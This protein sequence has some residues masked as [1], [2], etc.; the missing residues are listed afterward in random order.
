MVSMVANHLWQSTLFAVFVGLLTLLFRNNGAH[1]RHGLWLAASIKFLLPFSVL[2][3]LGSQLPWHAN[4]SSVGP[5]SAAAQW[6]ATL[7]TIA[8]PMP[9]SEARATAPPQSTGSA[10]RTS[11]RA[12]SSIDPVS[13]L[14]ALWVCGVAIVLFVSLVRWLRIS[15]IRRGAQPF[16][17]NLPT[18]VCIAVKTSSAMMEPG[19]IGVLRPTLLMPDGIDELLSPEQLQ[20]IVAHELCH[21]RRRDNLTGVIHMIVEA[22]CWFHPLVWW[23]GNRLIEERERACDE[24]VLGG[25]SDPYIYAEGLLTVCEAYVATPLPCAAGVSGADLNKRIAAIMCGK[26]AD[27]LHV[28]KQVLLMGSV[29]VSIAAPIVVGVLHAPAALALAHGSPMFASVSIRLAWPETAQKSMNL[30]DGQFRLRGNALRSIIA[31]AYGKQAT[32]VVGP[33]DPLSQ[34]YS[35]DGQ[36]PFVSLPGQIDADARAMLR[37]LLADRFKLAFH[38]EERRIPVYVLRN[39]TNFGITQA[40]GAYE[41]GPIWLKGFNSVGGRALPL[42][43][44]IQYLSTRL[45]RPIV[46][47]TGLSGTY[48]FKLQW[49]LEPNDPSARAK[50]NDVPSDPDGVVLVDGIRRQLGMQIESQQRVVKLLTVDRVVRP[51][52]TPDLPRALALDP[53]LSGRYVGH[54]SLAGSTILAVTRDGDHLLARLPGQIPV[55]YFAGNESVFFAKSIDAQITWMTDTR[56]QVTELVLHQNGK[57]YLAPRMDETVAQAQMDALAIRVRAQSAAP[58]TEA[59]LR[60]YIQGLQRGDLTLDDWIPSARPGIRSQGATLKWRFGIVGQLK[61]LTFKGVTQNGFD[62]YE[63]CFEKDSFQWTIRL[64]PDGKIDTLVFQLITSSLPQS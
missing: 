59:E 12:K 48:N 19:V 57:D 15:A 22:V 28:A 13:I 64:A 2:I 5:G 52:Q 4:S 44:L 26:V 42:W 32:E 24:A 60:R 17:G 3:A 61:S 38:W 29:L 45:D 54:Y 14:F 43:R 16:S 34:Y 23:I 36:A 8:Q 47:E 21:V 58:G 31:Y 27:K 25:G 51:A 9:R 46:D 40:A 37:V 56:G 63:S 7:A 20:A 55:A 49:G 39:G 10:L 18:G 11:T 41:P 50:G 33:A 35:M 62:L 6:S 1:V 30:N 53:S